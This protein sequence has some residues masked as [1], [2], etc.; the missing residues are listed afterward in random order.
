MDKRVVLE[1]EWRVGFNSAEKLSTPCLSPQRRKTNRELLF[2]LQHIPQ[3]NGP[4]TPYDRQVFTGVAETNYSVFG[5]W[6]K[7]KNLARNDSRQSQ[8]TLPL[9]EV[10]A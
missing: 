6:P 7:S 10:G 8:G 3:P 4:N 2:L 5:K 9:W 1:D